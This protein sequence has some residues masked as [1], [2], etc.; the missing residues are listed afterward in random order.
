[1]RE[2]ET[3]EWGGK[4]DT[5]RVTVNSMLHVAEQK[6]RSAHLIAL[7]SHGCQR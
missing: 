3:R 7:S 5:V 4:D 6:M 2:R 1:M